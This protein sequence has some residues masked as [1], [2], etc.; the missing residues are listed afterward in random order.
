MEVGCLPHMPHKV[1]L[2]LPEHPAHILLPAVT[3]TAALWS[4]G[5]RDP[6]GL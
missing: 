2:I 3:V 4:E 5:R 1:G 6:A